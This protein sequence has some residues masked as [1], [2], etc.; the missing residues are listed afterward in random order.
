MYLHAASF[1]RHFNSTETNATAQCSDTTQDSKNIR[2]SESAT[3]LQH[4]QV[5]SL[6]AFLRGNQ[7]LWMICVSCR[8]KDC[9]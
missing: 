2:T 8:K 5:T 3:K 4:V 1:K 9:T 6:S 7:I